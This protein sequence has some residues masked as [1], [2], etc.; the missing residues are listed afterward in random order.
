MRTVVSSIKL[1]WAPPV[2]ILHTNRVMRYKCRRQIIVAGRTGNARV[3]GIS[4][5][6]EGLEERVA[7][8]AVGEGYVGNQMGPLGFGNS[9]ELGLV[10]KGE[11]EIGLVTT[12]SGVVNFELMDS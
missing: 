4:S 1:N 12:L 7:R 3:R 8:V 11:R 10:V 2:A 6:S 9:L 5:E